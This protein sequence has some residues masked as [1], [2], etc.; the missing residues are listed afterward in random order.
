MQLAAACGGEPSVSALERARRATVALEIQGRDARGVWVSHGAGSIIDPDGYVL[1]CEHVTAVGE[2]QHVILHDGRRAPYRVVARAGG[3]FDLAVLAFEPPDA[4]DAMPLAGGGALRVGEAVT[5]LGNPGGRGIRALRA[6]VR[7]VDAGAGTQLE[8]VDATVEPGDSGGP[9]LD[10][11]G[12]MVAHVHVAIRGHPSV[13]RHVRIEH[14]REAFRGWLWEGEG[15]PGLRID[16]DG[17]AARV[18]AVRPG[19]AA[20]RGG[21]RVDDVIRRVGAVAVGDG[22]AAVLRLLDM[23]SDQPT[24]CVVV[25]S[26][27]EHEILLRR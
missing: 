1:T 4:V 25:R 19:A 2:Q 15:R 9:V 18:L 5:I 22:I 10:G 21:M 13:S 11:R 6:R 14:A 16:C 12:H 17:G 23:P 24:R 20:A 27:R 3:S 7:R 8:T 26:G